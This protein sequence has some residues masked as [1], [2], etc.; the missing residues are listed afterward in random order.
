MSDFD[1]GDVTIEHA[2]LADRSGYLRLIHRPSG[3]SVEAHLKSQPVL[4]TAQELMTLLRQRLL[5][6]LRGSPERLRPL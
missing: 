2:K 4:R 5:A 6:R 1:E 3:L